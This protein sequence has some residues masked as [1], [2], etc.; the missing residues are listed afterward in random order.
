MV[1]KDLNQIMRE[2]G[3]PTY[4]TPVAVYEPLLDRSGGLA[5]INPPYEQTKCK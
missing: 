3:E 4:F 5:V 2:Q 1:E